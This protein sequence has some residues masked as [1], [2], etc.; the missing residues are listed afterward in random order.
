MCGMPNSLGRLRYFS[1][2]IARIDIGY[3][4][5]LVDPSKE[6]NETVTLQTHE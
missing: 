4:C 5:L 3:G 2:V 6:C 1:P